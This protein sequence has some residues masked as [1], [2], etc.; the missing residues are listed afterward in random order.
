MSDLCPELDSVWAF[1]TF[2]DSILSYYASA[3]RIFRVE[4]L[5]DI[6]L[7]ALKLLLAWGGIN[8]LTPTREFSSF[9]ESLPSNGVIG[10]IFLAEF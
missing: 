2:R 9:R 6:F 10:D 3:L 1:K 7:E 5:V 4:K 8:F